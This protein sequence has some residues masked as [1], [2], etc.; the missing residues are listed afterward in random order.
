MRLFRL[1][2][3]VLLVLA[4]AGCSQSPPPVSPQVQK[5]Y[6]E[7]VVN[8]RV[9]PAVEP[10]TY[11][12]FG[13]SITEGDSPDFAAGRFGSLSWAQYLGGDFRFIGGWAASGAQTDVILQNAKPVEAEVLVLVVGANDYANGVPFERTAANIVGM[14]KNSGVGR[15][16]ISAVPPRDA[17][18]E[19]TA[20]F[21]QGLERLAGNKSWEFVDAPAGVRAGDV[22][23]PGMSHDGVHP[24]ARAARIMGVAIGAAIRP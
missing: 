19:L 14:V 8:Q 16:V 1:L 18:P 2:A 13:D 20:E 21:N 24:T 10:L 3:V 15:V 17:T 9:T 22:Y 7:H 12:A 5:Y 4:A 23:A 6:D 11:A